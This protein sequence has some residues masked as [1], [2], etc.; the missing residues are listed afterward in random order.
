MRNAKYKMRNAKCEM[1]NV[2]CAVRNEKCVR[3]AKSEIRVR[4][5]NYEILNTNTI[6]NTVPKCALIGGVGSIFPS[7]HN[8]PK[9][10]F[11][12]FFAEE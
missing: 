9:H 11:S 6:C 3:N 1:L 8:T 4:Y 2:Q 7:F 10:N 12:V 5:T